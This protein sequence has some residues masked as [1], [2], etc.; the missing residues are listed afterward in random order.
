MVKRLLQVSTDKDSGKIRNDT[1][2]DHLHYK[3][4]LNGKLAKLLYIKNSSY[5]LH[6]KT[7]FLSRRH[8]LKRVFGHIGIVGFGLELASN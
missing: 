7:C 1:T 4:A 3:P 6:M 5:D 8:F 2:M